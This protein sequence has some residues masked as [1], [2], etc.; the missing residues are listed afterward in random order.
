MPQR[1]GARCWFPAG[2]YFIGGNLTMTAPVRFEGTLS[3]PDAARLSLLQNY[4]LD[5]YAEAFGDDVT[6][7]KKGFRSCSTSRI[8]R[9][10][11]SAAAAWC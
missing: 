2:T 10:S 4:D 7:L 3:M 5:G 11:T 8:S 9:P 6:G 1:R